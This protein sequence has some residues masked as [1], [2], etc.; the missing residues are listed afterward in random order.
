M[1]A[2]ILISKPNWTQSDRTSQYTVRL[3]VIEHFVRRRA[4]H[5]SWHEVLR[6]LVSSLFGRVMYSF[7]TYSR[8]FDL[9]QSRTKACVPYGLCHNECSVKM[10][11]FPGNIKLLS[12]R[13]FFK[14]LY[15]V[16]RSDNSS[17]DFSACSVLGFHDANDRQYFE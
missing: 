17:H 8:D 6:L 12:F 16:L 11:E 4:A 3:N 15:F 2:V 7:C 9:C 13:K 1:F 10:S 5:Y 14:E